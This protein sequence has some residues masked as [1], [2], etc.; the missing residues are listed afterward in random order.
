MQIHKAFLASKSPRRL[1]LLRFLIPKV[2]Q[3]QSLREE[4]RWQENQ[5]VVEYLSL[6]M[7]EK[8][9]G[10]QEA[11]AKKRLSSSR[12]SLVVAADTIVVRGR[13]V[14]GKPAGAQGAR[15]MLAELM[16]KEH[17]VQTAVYLGLFR[18]QKKIREQHFT[19]ITKMKFRNAANDEIK[20][21]VATGE[22]LDKSGS[23]GVQGPALEFVQSMEGSYSSVMGLP[24]SRIQEELVTWMGK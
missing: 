23:Y 3:I 11:F 6:C 10:A 7:K 4:P 13:K 21:Y 22:P 9:M 14:Y 12:C 24:M 2:E 1:E 17:Q 19:V 18:G 15:A 16:G 8:S 5:S 20:N